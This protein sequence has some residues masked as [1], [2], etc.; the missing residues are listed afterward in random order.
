V[1]P[2]LRN[3]SIHAL[4]NIMKYPLAITISTLSV[5]AFMA[6][7]IAS[8]ELTFHAPE[9]PAHTLMIKSVIS[10]CPAADGA[11]NIATMSPNLPWTAALATTCNGKP[12]CEV[13]TAAWYAEKDT[14][15]TCTEEIAIRFACPPND[16]TPHKAF[17]YEGQRDAL[18]CS[19]SE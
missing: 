5:F 18:S 3:L 16:P 1:H 17:L 2:S 6:W 19:T 10:R 8:G 4:N 7:V 13:D 12:T 11:E 14:T 15:P 9:P